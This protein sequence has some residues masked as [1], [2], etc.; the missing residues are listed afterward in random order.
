[1]TSNFVRNP[2]NIEA[3]TK[4]DREE[5]LKFPDTRIGPGLAD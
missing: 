4:I 2:K 3:E 1:M 5:I